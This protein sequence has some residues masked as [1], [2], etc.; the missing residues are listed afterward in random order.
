MAQ[1][2]EIPDPPPFGATNR[3]LWQQNKLMRKKLEKANEK[4]GYF[5]DYIKEYK[6]EGAEEL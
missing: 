3:F 1:K 6:K 5:L 2:I 4:L